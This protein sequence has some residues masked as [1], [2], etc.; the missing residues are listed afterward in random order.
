MRCATACT[1]EGLYLRNAAISLS[2]DIVRASLNS[3]GT[4]IVAAEYFPQFVEKN[5]P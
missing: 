5:T 2:Q 4:Y 3:D 1:I